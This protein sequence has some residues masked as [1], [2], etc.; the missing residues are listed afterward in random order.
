MPFVLWTTERREGKAAKE[1]ESSAGAKADVL[2]GIFAVL[3]VF[4]TS[5]DS[6]RRMGSPFKRREGAQ[7]ERFVLD[8]GMANAVQAKSLGCMDVVKEREIDHIFQLY[9]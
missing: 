5:L 9:K 2:R 8:K 1:G 7:M 4:R 3:E 6:R